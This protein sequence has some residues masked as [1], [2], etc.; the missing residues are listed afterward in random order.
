MQKFN[1]EV[2][3]MLTLLPLI[4]MYFLENLTRSEIKPI[5]ESVLDTIVAMAVEII[6]KNQLHLEENQ[7]QNLT[8]MSCPVS[9]PTTRAV[10]GV[11]PGI[12]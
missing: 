7:R 9:R 8:V 1:T 2:R 5:V 10:S 4:N 11:T 6:E 3:H 12:P